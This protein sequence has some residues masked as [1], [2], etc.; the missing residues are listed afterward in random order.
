MLIWRSSIAA[1]SLSISQ[2]MT[3][4][5]ICQYALADAVQVMFLPEGSQMPA[6][7]MGDRDEDLHERPVPGF[8]CC[9]VRDATTSPHCHFV[10]D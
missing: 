3:I 9:K 10:S 4:L 1:D 6:T 8:L 2:V 7:V 5:T